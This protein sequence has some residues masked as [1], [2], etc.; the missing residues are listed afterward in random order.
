MMT[1]EDKWNAMSLEDKLNNAIR[2][3]DGDDN[4][5]ARENL[6]DILIDIQEGRIV[7]NKISINPP[8][9]GSLPTR[10]L[11]ATGNDVLDVFCENKNKCEQCRQ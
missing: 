3:I 9:I 10:C 6:V 2:N 7:V 11:T 8:V 4:V 5:G 1:W